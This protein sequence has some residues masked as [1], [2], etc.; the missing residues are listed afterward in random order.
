MQVRP[1][2][3][4]GGHLVKRGGTF[5]GMCVLLVACSDGGGPPTIGFAVNMAPPNAATVAMAALARR[6]RPGMPTIRIISGIGGAGRLPDEVDRA[7]RFVK[8]PEIVAVVGPGGSRQTL[9]TAPVFRDGGMPNIA[10][11]S[12]S[13]RLHAVGPWTFMLAP[14]DSVQ[15]EFLGAIAHDRLH[16]RTAAVLYVPDEYGF[17]LATG[18]AAALAKRGIRLIDRV[19]IAEGGNCTATRMDESAREIV[20]TILL[21]GTPD[22]VVLA[23][24]TRE[25]GCLVQAFHARLPDIRFLA[26]DGVLVDASFLSVAGK[27]LDSMYFAGFWHPDL[28]DS[29]SRRFVREFQSLVG[30]TPRHDDAMY[31]DGLMV[32][33]EAIRS[34]GADRAAI[35]DYLAS[36]GRERPPFAGV[37]GPIGFAPGSVH[38]LVMFRVR[39][40]RTELVH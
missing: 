32:I 4:I 18:T 28:P 12:T 38:P 16:A 10:P 22:I 15:G 36:L 19:P 29:G 34:V 39:D 25:A 13:A 2:I 6:Q 27:G 7:L 26:G 30:R 9:Q 21:E 40:G 31:Y 33:A 14:D 8:N 3:R 23:T 24:R 20:A 1:H 37:T 17:G 35:R 5:F 11:T